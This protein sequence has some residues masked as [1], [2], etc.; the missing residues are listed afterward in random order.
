MLAQAQRCFYEKAVAY[1]LVITPTRAT[2]TWSSPPQ[3]QRCFYEKAVRDSMSPK[4][5]E[6]SL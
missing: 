6:P 1:Y 3:A 4:L 2:V 5:L